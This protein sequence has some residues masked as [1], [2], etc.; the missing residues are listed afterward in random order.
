MR[1]ADKTVTLYNR[2]Y[3][4]GL[5]LDTYKQTSIAGV[6]WFGRIQTTVSSDGG[7]LAANEFT[8]RIPRERAGDY[9]ESADYT[10]EANT[11]TLA[12]D[13]IIVLGAVTVENPTRKKLFD[14]FNNIMTVLAVTDNRDGSGGHIKV[15]GK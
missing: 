15:V 1:H 10:G 9:V 8:V 3:D 6:S 14:T 4:S 5:G 2:Y 7:L 13:D 11:W 12:P